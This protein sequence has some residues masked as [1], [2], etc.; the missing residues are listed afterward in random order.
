MGRFPAPRRRPVSCNPTTLPLLAAL[1]RHYDELF[2][3]LRRRFGTDPSVAHDVVHDVC[4]NLLAEPPRQAVAAP[5]AYVRRATLNLAIDRHRTEST[6]GTW[7]ESTADLPE[8]ADETPGHDRQ[9]DAGRELDRLSAAIAQLPPRCR[10]VFV[11]HKIHDMPQTEVAVRLGI[12]RKAVEKHIRRGMS[13]CRVA[14][15]RP[16]PR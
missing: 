13:A 2:D 6:R 7:V 10:E 3:L 12:S 14:L 8:H 4:V 1:V 15:D 5:A 11:L 9:V 16:G